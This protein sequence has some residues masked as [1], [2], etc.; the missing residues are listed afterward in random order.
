MSIQIYTEA[1]KRLD[2]DPETGALFWKYDNCMPKRWNTRYAGK[3][4][5]CKSKDC[6]KIKINH[7]DGIEYSLI[8]RRIAW[9]ITH[10]ELPELVVTI[11]GNPYDDSISNLRASTLIAEGKKAKM[12]SNNKTGVAGVCYLKSRGKYL[13]TVKCNRSTKGNTKYFDTLVDAEA[14]VKQRRLEL[15]FDPDLHG[16]G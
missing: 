11:N 6:R 13:A 15:G 16:R 4:A 12:P 14:W 2:Y 3:Q 7:G 8:S 1:A 9:F 10:G 5:G